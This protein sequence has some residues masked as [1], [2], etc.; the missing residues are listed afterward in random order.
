MRCSYPVNSQCYFN[1]CL[2]LASPTDRHY[3]TDEDGGCY[4]DSQ[5][6]LQDDTT[7]ISSGYNICDK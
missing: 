1:W 3:H 6:I 5:E 2:W 4:D 7:R